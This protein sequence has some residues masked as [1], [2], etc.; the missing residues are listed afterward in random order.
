VIDERELLIDNAYYD[1]RRDKLRAEKGA[2]GKTDRQDQAELAR[3]VHAGDARAGVDDV[4]RTPIVAGK[5]L[6][7]SILPSRSS[8]IAEQLS[9]Q[10]PQ[11]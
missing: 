8:T 7:I 6:T 2:G 9:T 3:F 11:L 5:K 10:S 4:A 1:F